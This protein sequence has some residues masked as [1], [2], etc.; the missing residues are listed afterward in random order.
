MCG[1]I[2]DYNATTPSTAPG[3]LAM[4]LIRRVRMQGFVIFDHWSHYP[5]F[6][7]EIGPKVAKGVIDYEET[8]EGG[9]ESTP[10]AF[11]KL[12]EGA[13]KGKMLVRL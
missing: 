4:I 2:A 12:L 6:L 3:N 1:L 8:I 13:N 7:E 5:Q 9:L 10:D 11:L